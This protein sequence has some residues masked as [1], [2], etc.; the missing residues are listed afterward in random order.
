MP[1][2]SGFSGKRGSDKQK[3]LRHSVSHLLKCSEILRV[4]LAGQI[5]PCSGAPEQSLGTIEHLSQE[6]LGVRRA[7]G[8]GLALPHPGPLVL[9]EPSGSEML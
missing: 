9:Q 8:V 6:S 2:T 4:G 7:V 3:H 1:L 5:K